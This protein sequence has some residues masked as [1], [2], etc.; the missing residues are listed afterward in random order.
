[1]VSKD[2]KSRGTDFAL[3]RLEKK[4]SFKTVFVCLGRR[5]AWSG[6][7]R[8]GPES[9]H[10]RSRYAESS[11]SVNFRWVRWGISISRRRSEVGTPAYL[12][13]RD[14]CLFFFFQKRK[15][16]STSAVSSSRLRA[17]MQP[18]LESPNYLLPLDCGISQYAGKRS[19]DPPGNS[20]DTDLD[21]IY[22]GTVVPSQAKYPWMAWGGLNPTQMGCGGALINDRYVLT[23]AHCVINKWV[24]S[25]FCSSHQDSTSGMKLFSLVSSVPTQCTT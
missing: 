18:F 6:G 7:Y 4:R 13:S 23:A 20:T 1:M 16:A 19:G 21:R 17:R 11:P 5:R 24:S 3:P 15:L 9:F 14:W 10:P 12:F 25:H 8:P 22:G 2:T